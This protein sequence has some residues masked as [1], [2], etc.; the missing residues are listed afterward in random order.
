MRHTVTLRLGCGNRLSLRQVGSQRCG[1]FSYANPNTAALA[2]GDHRPR[3]RC[4]ATAR[5]SDRSE[6]L[7][8][9]AVSIRIA[10]RRARASGVSKR[11]RFRPQLLRAGILRVGP[12][13]RE[14]C[15]ARPGWTS[16]VAATIPSGRDAHSDDRPLQV[17]MHAHVPRHVGH[18]G[19]DLRSVDGCR[20]GAQGRNRTADTVI[21]SHVLYQ[22]SYLGMREAGQGPS[23]DGGP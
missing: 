10:G 20:N 17:Q 8:F 21:F 14:I 6:Q 5:R 9:P 19:N 22:L 4:D 3:R 15:G 11:I 2:R 23:S 1:N 16:G 7:Q 13:G 12:N 18:D